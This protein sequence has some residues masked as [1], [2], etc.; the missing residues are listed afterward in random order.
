MNIV[1][2]YV[3]R[4]YMAGDITEAKRIIRQ[5]CYLHGLCV[6]IEPTSFI[7]TAGEEA[8]I[9]VGFV[10][11]PRFAATPEFIFTRA[12]SLAEK[13]LPELNQRTALVVGS[14]KTEWIIKDAPGGAK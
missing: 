10:N 5:E 6:T 7:Y 13:L 2:T 4:L 14:D 12:K 3:V 9:V 1:D 11:Y 8:G